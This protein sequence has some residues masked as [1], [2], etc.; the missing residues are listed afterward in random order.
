M[1][2]LHVQ[3]KDTGIW[4]WIVGLL[5]LVAALWFAF[6]RND[7]VNNGLA[8]AAD[9]TYTTPAPAAPNAPNPSTP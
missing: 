3:K 5:I 7:N 4:P 6:G 2:E 8:A 9:S 1:A